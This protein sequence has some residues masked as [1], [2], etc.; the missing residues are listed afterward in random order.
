VKPS[1]PVTPLADPRR[2]MPRAAAARRAVAEA[3]VN[4][5]AA[6]QRRLATLGEEWALARTGYQLRYW[7]FVRALVGLDLVSEPRAA[8]VVAKSRRAA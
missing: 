7:R 6:E 3:A 1:A 4:S 2:A 5:L 8:R